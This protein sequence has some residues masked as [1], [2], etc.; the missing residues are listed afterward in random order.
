MLSGLYSRVVSSH[1]VC[2]THPHFRAGGS[3]DGPSP[4]HL[5]MARCGSSA[6]SCRPIQNSSCPR[7][8]SASTAAP[9]NTLTASGM[10][11]CGTKV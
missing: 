3:Y 8:M 10:G 2:C 9:A 5:A 7:M 4:L 6:H 11:L 1:K